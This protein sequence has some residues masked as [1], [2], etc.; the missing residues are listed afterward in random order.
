MKPVKRRKVAEGAELITSEEA[1]EIIK[2]SQERTSKVIKRNSPKEHKEGSSSSDESIEE[3]LPSS[4]DSLDENT[5]EVEDEN[6]NRM[7]ENKI[8]DVGQW[9]LVKYRVKFLRYHRSGKFF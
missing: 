9:F 6:E 1:L 7:P 5:V 2:D 4:S 8:A 3:Q